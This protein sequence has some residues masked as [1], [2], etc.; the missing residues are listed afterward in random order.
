ME[1]KGVFLSFDKID[2]DVVLRLFEIM[3]YLDS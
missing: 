3:E 2:K 1:F